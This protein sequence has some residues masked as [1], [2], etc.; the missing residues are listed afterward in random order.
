MKLNIALSRA[1]LVVSLGSIILGLG[2]FFQRWE[3][4]QS[5]LHPVTASVRYPVPKLVPVAPIPIKLAT[6]SAD[7]TFLASISAE[8]VYVMDVES[9]VPLLAKNERA[10][11]YPA[12]TTKLLT[13]LVALDTYQLDDVLTATDSAS[14]SGSVLGILPG[15]KYTVRDV[16][17]AMLLPSA[18]D[19]ALLFA[20][21]HPQGFMGFVAEMNRK[22]Q[23]LHLDTSRFTNPNGLDA[24]GQQTSVR[25]LALLAR[26]VLRQPMVAELVGQISYPIKELGSGQ[27]AVVY[28]TNELLRENRG[29]KGVKTGT[30]ELAREMLVSMYEKNGHSVIIVVAGS[31]DRYADTRAIQDWIENSYTWTRPNFGTLDK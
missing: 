6:A 1:W 29:F 26:E 10:T 15:D 17:A 11:V 20:T 8:A 21:S 13:A 5:L 12:S 22:A 2:L 23:Q 14:T 18:N 28:N 30:T 25:E 19:A 7:A 9:A 16:M 27:Q 31:S 4:W 24:L 3:E